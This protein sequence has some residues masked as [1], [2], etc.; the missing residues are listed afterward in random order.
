M[1]RAYSFTVMSFGL[2]LAS[3]ASTVGCGGDD[4]SAE[5]ENQAGTGGSA[6]SGGSSGSS[7]GTGGT[8]GT[9][10]ALPS[11]P[12]TCGM[13]EPESALILDFGTYT[14]SGSWGS[15]A[16]T[17]GTS[18]Y[19][20][21]TGPRL[22]LTADAGELHVTGNVV[23]GGY[24]G[25]VFWL[26]PCLNASNY[27]GFTFEMGG[28]LGGTTA[29]FQVQT[30]ETY[31]VDVANTKGACMFTNCDEK[32]SQCMGPTQSITVPETAEAIS[33]AWDTFPDG[34]T[35]EGAAPISADGIVGIQFQFDGCQTAEGCPI[36]VTIGNI[37]LI[38]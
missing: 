38:E 33:L 11:G 36:D 9:M 23:T 25:F 6:G 18:I 5:R 35:P 26:A 2:A 17:G 12:Q 7:S 10:C 24:E 3:V 27:Q 31:P 8:A 29:K 28:T 4:S 22:T 14:S 13:T 30:D 37:S 15:G 19:G 1:P 34:T 20:F 32:W 21:E 16:V